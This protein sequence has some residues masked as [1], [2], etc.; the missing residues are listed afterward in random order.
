[1]LAGRPMADGERVDV[2]LAIAPHPEEGRALGRADPL[3]TVGAVIRGAEPAQ[4]DGHHAGSMRTVDERLHPALAQLGDETLHGQDE[5]GGAGDVIEQGQARAGRHPRHYGLDDHVRRRDGERDGHDL[6]PGARAPRHK[7][8]G[9]AAGAVD[10]VRG[11]ELIALLEG[12]RAQHG[13]D[14]AR[15]VAD[16]G[17]VVGVA[18][19]EGGEGL[20]GLVEAAVQLAA[21]EA[22][23]LRFQLRAESGLDVEHLPGTG[24]VGAVVQEG[25]VALQRPERG[26]S[27]GASHQ[28]QA[29]NFGITSRPSQAS[30]PTIASCGMPILL[31][32]CTYS[33]PGNF[34]WREWSRA[35][36]SSGVPT[37]EDYMK[38][39]TPAAPQPPRLVEASSCAGVIP[40]T[41]P[42]GPNIF[43]CSSYHGVISRTA[44]ARESA[45]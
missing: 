34:S 5:T 30:C 33:R 26:E 43:T 3:V 31:L 22:H 4:I 7:V 2:G 6:H 23:G 38:V 36:S 19:H 39:G 45:R 13:V 35:M 18:A 27:L 44:R 40:G 21:K 10:V 16:E 32:R 37:V 24:A 25:D 9:V 11:E 14:A 28:G 20:A 17:E 1:M 8:E 42:S 12:E 41:K 29:M 15:G